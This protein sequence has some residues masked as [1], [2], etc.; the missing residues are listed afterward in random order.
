MAWALWVVQ[1]KVYVRH[2]KL[3]KF[4]TKRLCSEIAARLTRVIVICTDRKSKKASQP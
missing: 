1:C 4:G 3:G 2:L